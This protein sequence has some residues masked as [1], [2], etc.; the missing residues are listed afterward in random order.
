MSLIPFLTGLMLLAA[1]TGAGAMS[2][3][4]GF[5]A[6]EAADANDE[7]QQGL[8]TLYEGVL[9]DKVVVRKTERRLYLMKDDRPFRSYPVSLG[10]NPVGHKLAQGDGRTPEG[11]YVLDWRNQRSQFYKSINISYPSPADRL[12]SQR[13]GVNPGGLIMI[14]GQPRPNHHR[15]LQQALSSE[16]W[17]QGCVA[18][19]NLA[20]DEIWELTRDGTPIEILP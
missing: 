18:V 11:S 8:Q 10:S 12:R 14:H 5:F 15:E 13:L 4:P 1:S 2:F 6:R 19:S 7:V 17:T 16:D 3:L 20:I 9:A